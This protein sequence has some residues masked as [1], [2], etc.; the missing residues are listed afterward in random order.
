MAGSIHRCHQPTKPGVEIGRKTAKS[1]TISSRVRRKTGKS[2]RRNLEQGMRT[3]RNGES[4]KSRLA[5][6]W[7][8][9]L[10]EKK[11]GVW[12]LDR[13]VEMAPWWEILKIWAWWELGDIYNIISGCH[14]VV[15]LSCNTI[16]SIL[17][18]QSRNLLLFFRIWMGIYLAKLKKTKNKKKIYISFISSLSSASCWMS[19][20]RSSIIAH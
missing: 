3:V 2:S 8:P 11:S 13:R 14:E 20:N 12:N 10:E 4:E 15:W 17:N 18:M 9:T 6:T 1:P 19:H 7:N 5:R 16:I